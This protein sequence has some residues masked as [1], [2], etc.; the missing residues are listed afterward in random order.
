MRNVFLIY[1]YILKISLCATV[2]L[3][4]RGSCKV[5]FRSTPQHTT[6]TT[7]CTQTRSHTRDLAGGSRFLAGCQRRTMVYAPGLQYL[8]RGGS[9]HLCLL[10]RRILERQSYTPD[11]PPIHS[12]IPIPD[13]GFC[14]GIGVTKPIPDHGFAKRRLRR[15]AAAPDHISLSHRARARTLSLTAAPRRPIARFNPIAAHIPQPIARSS[16]VPRPAWG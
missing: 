8:E 2:Q 6:D 14:L 10:Y 4:E 3:Q 15:R 12:R 11:T 1:I 16:S 9:L 7:D 5:Y 13:P